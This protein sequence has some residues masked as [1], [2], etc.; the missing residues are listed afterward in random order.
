[1]EGGQHARVQ[2]GKRVGERRPDAAF[3]ESSQREEEREG[4]S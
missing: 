2:A 1:M 3:F 4:E